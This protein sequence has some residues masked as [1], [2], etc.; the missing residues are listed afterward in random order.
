MTPHFQDGLAGTFGEAVAAWMEPAVAPDERFE[1]PHH[2]FVASP[3]DRDR[4]ENSV[5][6]PARPVDISR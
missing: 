4:G 5:K 3:D 2:C 6:H 1:P